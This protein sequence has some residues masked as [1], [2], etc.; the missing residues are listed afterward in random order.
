[1]H[2]YIRALVRFGLVLIAFSGAFF[3]L[4]AQKQSYPKDYYQF[5]IRP[6]LPNSLAG[7][8]GDLRTNHFHAGLDIRTEQREG[9]PVHA[10]ADGYVYKVGSKDW[11]WKCRFFAS[12]KWPNDGIWAFTEI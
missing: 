9:L 3:P 12:S 5:P 7:G 8:L 4:S 10:A 11:L 6:G 2:N 1:M